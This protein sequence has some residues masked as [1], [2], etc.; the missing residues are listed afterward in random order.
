VSVFGQNYMGMNEVA[1]SILPMLETVIQGDETEVAG[2]RSL[3]WVWSV[4]R[5]KVSE[6]F[7]DV[8]RRGAC[9]VEVQRARC[10]RRD[11]RK[12]NMWDG[13]MLRHDGERTDRSLRGL[14]APVLGAGG[15]SL[16]D[17][18]ASA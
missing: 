18:N 14:E 15:R 5:L 10:D 3:I 4:A 7:R 2:P 8:E 13:R 6:N 9:L 11:W 12:K 1:S 16:A 17:L